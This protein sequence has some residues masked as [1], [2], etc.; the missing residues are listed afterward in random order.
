MDLDDILEVLAKIGL[1]LLAI[2]AVA[3]LAYCFLGWILVIVA[4]VQG[5][6][7]LGLTLLIV[8]MI[9]SGVKLFQYQ[10]ISP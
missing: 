9:V 2:V 6:V 5:K 10:I 1:A 3:I 8:W 7:V 4:F